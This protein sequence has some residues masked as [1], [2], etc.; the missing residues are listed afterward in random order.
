KIV[1]EDLNVKQM[2]MSHVAS[3]GLQRS[4]FGYFKQVLTYKCEWYGKELILADKYYPSTQRCS[5]CGFVKTKEDKI[6]LYGNE[7]HGT[8][9]NEYV[10]YDCGAIMDRDMNA[11]KNLLTLA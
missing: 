4:M 1:I 10:C 5:E 2:K 3:K 8:K 11:V 7:K 9:H 6:T